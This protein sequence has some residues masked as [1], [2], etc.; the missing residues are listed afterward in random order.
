MN[1]ANQRGQTFVFLFPLDDSSRPFAKSIP[2]DIVLSIFFSTGRSIQP[3]LAS[4]PSY[5][6]IHVIKWK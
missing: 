5:Y 2:K 4:T 3:R 1:E 6:I